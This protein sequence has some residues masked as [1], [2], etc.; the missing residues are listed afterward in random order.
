MD[1]LNE[2]LEKVNEHVKA[3]D[4]ARA[5][6]LLDEYRVQDVAAVLSELDR[7]DALALFRELD[8]ELW[9]TAFSYLEHDYQVPLLDTLEQ[10][11]GRFILSS[12]DPDDRTA[13]FEK[14]PEAERKRLLRLMPARDIKQALRLLGYPPESTGR[15]MTPD[16]VAVRPDW[17]VGEA[18]DHLR[19]RGE[20]GETINVVYVTDAQ[21][22]LVGIVP[23][24][25]FV[26]GKPDRQVSEIMTSDVISAE[27]SEDREDTLQTIQHYDLAAVP[28]VDENH[29]LV[30]IVTYDDM[31]DVAEAE[32]TEDFHKMGSVG[33]LNLNLNAASPWLLFQK[34]VGWL[35]I[36][37]FV[38]MFAGEIIGAYEDA[39]EGLFVLMTFLPLVVDSGGNAGTQ[40]ATL[41]VRALATGDVKM[42]DWFR[43]LA[44]ELGVALALG[45]AMA[46]AVFMVAY[47][48]RTE[49]VFDVSAVIALGMIGVVTVG[50]LVGMLLPFGL[51][52]LNLDPATASAPLITSIADL[53]G[54]AMYFGIAAWILGLTV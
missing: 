18:L 4:L 13:F 22:R 23:L 26:L 24:K 12:M 28:V 29:R 34:R 8:R 54:I 7:D 16:F 44:K 10:E 2:L 9:A 49:A 41:M 1:E 37:V 11:D 19:Q 35:L 17:S 5:R 25:R 51:A 36:L 43:L 42:G 14:L 47:F 46:I 53:A 15:R 45:L 3:G 52:K 31:M 32:S 50:S 30:G 6:Q 27:V 38:N 33:V 21:E 40:S 48:W 20:E 39:L